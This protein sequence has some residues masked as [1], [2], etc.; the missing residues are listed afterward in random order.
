MA[1]ESETEEKGGGRVEG[2]MVPRQDTFGAQ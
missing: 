2:N 1:E